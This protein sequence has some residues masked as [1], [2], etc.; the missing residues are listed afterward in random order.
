[1]QQEAAAKERDSRAATGNN[2]ADPAARNFQ[3]EAWFA[4][5]PPSLQ[6]AI[7]SKARR[8]APRGYEERLKRYFESD[9]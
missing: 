8:G 6:K 5:L 2:S 1:M 9:R 3:D 7:Q 4:K